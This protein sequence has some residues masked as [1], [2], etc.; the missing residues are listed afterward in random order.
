MLRVINY[1]SDEQH[2]RVSQSFIMNTLNFIG[3]VALALEQFSYD[4]NYLE[5]HRR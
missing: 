3:V 2:Q 4:D 1:R 5:K